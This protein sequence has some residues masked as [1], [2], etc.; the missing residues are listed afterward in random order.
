LIDVV[1]VP[2]IVGAV[3]GFDETVIANAGSAAVA[4]PSLT[5]ITI[6]ICEAAAVGVPVNRPVV[7]EKVA[8]V[9]RLT[10]EKVS[11][12]PSASDAVG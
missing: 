2:E 9:G 8:Q 1:G 7:L 10:I 11:V 5:L 12:L 3:F 6:L 4:V